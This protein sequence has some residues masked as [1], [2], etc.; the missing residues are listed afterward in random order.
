MPEGAKGLAGALEGMAGLTSL[1]LVRCA[2]SRTAGQRRLP[3]CA[4]RPRAAPLPPSIRPPPLSPRPPPNSIPC[5]CCDTLRT[6]IETQ[7]DGC[8]DCKWKPGVLV[9]RE[10]PSS[11][12]G[13]RA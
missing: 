12:N 2:R 13:K 4:N 6:C 10:R 1:D 9:D 7:E 3:R 5:P 8:Y 11:H